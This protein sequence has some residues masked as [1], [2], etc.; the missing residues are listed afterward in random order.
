MI[1]EFITT[2]K[3]PYRSK[4]DDPFYDPPEPLLIGKAY[5]KLLYVA[6]MLDII[7][8]KLNV[9]SH[10]KTAGEIVVS[11]YPSDEFG[12]ENLCEILDDEELIE[13]P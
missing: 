1:E 9:V 5:I 10:G 6:S 13:D 7:D 11:M 3:I 2:D 12:K 4:E 8:Y